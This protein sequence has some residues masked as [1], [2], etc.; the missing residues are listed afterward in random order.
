MYQRSIFHH[1]DLTSLPPQS[2][3]MI[4]EWTSQDQT[5][6]DI[7]NYYLACKPLPVNGPVLS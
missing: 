7:S 2:T 6:V 5:K 4:I 3:L 1:N